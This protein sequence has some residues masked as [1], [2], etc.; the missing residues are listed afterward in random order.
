M[1]DWCAVID[2]SCAISYYLGSKSTDRAAIDHL[3][4]SHSLLVSNETH[5]EFREVILRTKFDRIP[6]NIRLGF[7]DNYSKL[8][9]LLD[10][11]ITVHACIDPKDDKF[12]SLAVS[13]NASLILTND[14]HLLRLHPF[15]G[16]DIL[17]PQQYLDKQTV[18][19]EQR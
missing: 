6:R 18:P 7:V 16:I 8:V 9:E 5:S 19:P 4:K 13:A 12:L 1:T 15:R 17:T 14:N 3:R 2:T 11:H 10:P